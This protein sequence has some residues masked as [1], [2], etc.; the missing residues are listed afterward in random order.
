MVWLL[1]QAWL[2]AALQDTEAVARGSGSV[3]VSLSK[4]GRQVIVRGHVKAPLTMP[5]ARTLDPAEVDVDAELLLMLS[6]APGREPP[7]KSPKSRRASKS[8]HSNAKG[9][10]SVAG[11]LAKERVISDLDAA[12]DFYSGDEIV[13]DEFVRQYILLE[14]P[15][16]PLRSD[17]RAMDN[18]AIPGPPEQAS[19][20]SG[21]RID[22]R[23]APLA[24]IAGRLKF[25]TKE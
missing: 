9:S 1:E 18:P 7:A 12:Q 17:L 16:F 24:E 25:D 14:L 11:R 4:D 13:L 20:S 10:E 21:N 15:M 6:P 5:C 23:L 19:A 8:A 3:D 22:P 2:D